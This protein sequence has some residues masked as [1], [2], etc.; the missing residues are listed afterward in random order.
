MRRRR[1]RLRCERL[2]ARDSAITCRT[3]PDALELE[4]GYGDSATQAQSAATP[5]F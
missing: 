1:L 3:T 4:H 2:F 5:D